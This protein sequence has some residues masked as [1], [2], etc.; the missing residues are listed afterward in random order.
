MLCLMKCHNMA[1]IIDDAYVSSRASSKEIMD[2]H[3]SLLKGW[4][5]DSASENVFGAVVDLASAKD[6]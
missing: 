2:Q 1:G 6:V 5:F 3:D 4:I